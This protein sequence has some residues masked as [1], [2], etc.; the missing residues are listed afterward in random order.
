MKSGRAAESGREPAHA[1]DINA[2]PRGFRLPPNKTDTDNSLDFELATEAA[3]F[4]RGKKI[5]DKRGS[6]VTTRHHYATGAEIGPP[7]VRIGEIR[8]RGRAERPRNPLP[9]RVRRAWSARPV[10]QQAK[11]PV[12]QREQAR[13][14]ASLPEQQAQQV[15]PQVFLRVSPQALRAQT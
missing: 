3:P 10:S 15:F 14:S 13:E 4:F 6:A 8:N 2:N 5:P 9:V 12:F 7:P 11:E 1:G